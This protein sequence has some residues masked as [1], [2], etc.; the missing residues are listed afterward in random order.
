MMF[1]NA[2]PIAS[3]CF[4][5][6]DVVQSA[7]NAFIQAVTDL[8]TLGY[9]LN[10]DLHFVNIRVQDRDLR[11]SFNANF[12]Q[13]LNNKNF[14]F[15]M[16]RSDQPTAQHWT[17]SYE[18]KW[19]QSSLNTLLRRPN[20]NQVRTFYEKALALKIMSLDLSTAEHTTYSKKL[21]KNS[22]LPPLKK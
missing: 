12:T 10:I 11:H 17:T 7:H 20:S 5:G 1:C 15:K 13:N 8:T 9:G 22:Q 18:S 14:E 19:A 2:G 3:S 4:L 6:K 21:T 16:R